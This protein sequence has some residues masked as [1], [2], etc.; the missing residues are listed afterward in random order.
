MEILKEIAECDQEV[1]VISFSRNFGHQ[2][3]VSA[4]IHYCLGD[5]AVIIDA[6][7]QDPPELIPELIALWKQELCDVVYG[8][9]RERKG[10]SIFK[11]LTAKLFYR[12]INFLSEVPIPLDAGD[13]R[14]IN[15]NVIREFKR[16]KERNKY[17]R[18]L[19]SWIGFKQIPFYYTRDPRLAGE[20]KYPLSKMIKFAATG[21][22]YFTKKPL[23][24]ATTLGFI[25][26]IIS[27]SLAVYVFVE[28]FVLN[29]TAPGWASTVLVILFLGGVQLLT[30]G[31][32]GE[33]LGNI[34]DEIKQRPEYIVAETINFQE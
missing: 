6:D 30:L 13:F 5:A 15:Q 33:Y 3:A 22:T 28:K 29:S 9:R 26:I 8:V 17:I 14:L 27:L 11:K 7:L 34:F 20:T 25:S 31:V 32:I 18:G 19:I 4:G 1:K 24:L 21:L 16:L 12:T 10:E 2:T 23:K